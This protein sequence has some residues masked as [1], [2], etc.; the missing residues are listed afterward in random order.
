MPFVFIHGVNS[1]D[2]GP[3]SKYSHLKQ[4]IGAEVREHVLEPLGYELEMLWPYWGQYAVS[5]NYFEKGYGILT[6]PTLGQLQELSAEA[7]PSAPELISGRAMLISEAPLHD[8]RADD[9][10]LEHQL[11]RLLEQ[12]DIGDAVLRA[13]TEAEAAAL[14]AAA[15]P[16]LQPAPDVELLGTA[17]DLSSA[18]NAAKQRLLR[19]VSDAVIRNRRQAAQRNASR[20]MGDAFIYARDRGTRARPGKI[21]QEVL[22]ALRTERRP[23][24]PLIVMTHSMGGN[25]LY[26][27]LKTYDP[28]L[29]VDF[30]IAVGSQVGHFEDMKLFCASD[31]DIRHPRKVPKPENVKHWFNVYDPGDVIGFLAEPVFEGVRDI[32]YSTGESA[33]TAHAAY[34]HQPAFYKLVGQLLK[35]PMA[36]PAADKRHR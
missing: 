12:P 20:F 9:D 19:A 2:T 28:E 32:R 6:I 13:T 1:R 22:Q 11:Q 30:W 8:E 34:F 31:P 24:E 5:F 7:D 4:L 36:Q 29:Q 21:I 3:D 10:A 18:M 14:L 26:E 35:D 27:I 33:L 23:G 17:S 15:L 25:I 16:D